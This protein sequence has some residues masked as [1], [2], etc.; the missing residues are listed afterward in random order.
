MK[1]NNKFKSQTAAKR[2]LKNQARLKRR[3]AEYDNHTDLLYSLV[4]RAV[5]L[6]FT[7]QLDDGRTVANFTRKQYAQLISREELDKTLSRKKD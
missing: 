1:K 2:G 4:Q 5:R 3:Q 6:E 7:R